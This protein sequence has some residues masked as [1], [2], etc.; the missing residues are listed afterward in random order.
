MEDLRGL[1]EIAQ[2]W[3][4]LTIFASLDPEA[5]PS[6]ISIHAWFFWALSSPMKPKNVAQGAETSW[7]NLCVKLGGNSATT[8]PHQFCSK[9]SRTNT[10]ITPA[11][12]K[13]KKKSVLEQNFKLDWK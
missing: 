1:Q 4:L 11:I 12:K 5:S 9:F 2:I 13:G 10:I 7:N 8:Q 6:T 3:L